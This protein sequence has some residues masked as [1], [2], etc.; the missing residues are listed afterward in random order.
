MLEIDLTKLVSD[1]VAEFA[2][3]V[4]DRATS[5]TAD[6]F[7][8]FKAAFG[9]GFGDYLEDTLLRCSKIKTLLYRDQSVQISKLYVP[10]FF[11]TQGVVVGEDALFENLSENKAIIV[12]GSAGS[13]K[14][15]F[16]KNTVLRLMKAK[17]RKIPIFVELRHINHYSTSIMHYVLEHALRH[18]MPSFDESTLNYCFKSGLFTLVLDGFDEVNHDRRSKYLEEIAFMRRR[19]RD[20]EVIIS[21]RPED[22]TLA[23]DG[24]NIFHVKPLTKQHAILLISKLEYEEEIKRSFLTA[25]DERIYDEQPEFASS[26]LLLTMLLLTYDQVGEVPKK[27]HIFFDQAFETLVLKHDRLKAHYQRK[28]YSELNM[29]E[30]RKIYSM[31][32]ASSYSRDEISFTEE[33]LEELLSDALKFF[34]LKGDIDA[35]KKDLISSYCMLKRDG[36]FITFVHRSFQEYFCAYFLSR[37]EEIDLIQVVDALADRG[38]SEQCLD[39]LFDISPERVLLKWAYPT[40]AELAAKLRQVEGPHDIAGFANGFYN[41][42]R[43]GGDDLLYTGPRKGGFRRIELCVKLLADRLVEVPVAE[44]TKRRGHL[45]EVRVKDFFGFTAPFNGQLIEPTPEDNLWLEGS[46][47]AE[48][49]DAVRY[50]VSSGNDY[51]EKLDESRRQNSNLFEQVIAKQNIVKSSGQFHADGLWGRKYVDP[52]T[53]E[54]RTASVRKNF[55]RTVLNLAVEDGN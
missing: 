13:G 38:R 25:L 6:Q 48:Q 34:D 22:A 23:L 36:L 49:L 7:R 30:I 16:V 26:P 46:W 27:M 45:N 53:K 24:F 15:I 39:M 40:L 42:I 1:I 50:F 29:E 2:G 44:L 18:S 43:V 19:Y 11:E 9:V 20:L 17:S 12:V 47:L 14:T 37:T 21:T 55:V 8:K 3:P 41:G 33:R 31:F 28:T 52:D 51:L 54:E 4:I 5:L 35:L 32:C 10:A